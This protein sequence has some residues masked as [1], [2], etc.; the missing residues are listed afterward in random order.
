VFLVS[1]YRRFWVYAL[2]GSHPEEPMSGFNRV[3]SSPRV[4]T[5]Y[6]NVIKRICA[7]GGE[8]IGTEYSAL[9]D[10][11]VIFFGTKILMTSMTQQIFNLEKNC[12][13]K[14]VSTIFARPDQGKKDNPKLAQKVT[15]IAFIYQMITVNY[16]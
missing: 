9:S 10:D 11:N 4:F 16:I 1:G 6:R 3:G 7:I 8:L 13:L 14:M 2:M 15:Y 5:Y 12:A